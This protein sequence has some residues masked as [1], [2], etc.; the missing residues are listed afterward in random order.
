MLVGVSVGITDGVN[1][2][3]GVA[4]AVCDGVRL[5]RGVLVARAIA[6]AGR[7]GDLVNV[8]VSIVSGASVAGCGVAVSCGVTVLTLAKVFVGVDGSVVAVAAASCSVAM[9][10]AWVGSV[11]GSTVGGSVGDA[12]GGTNTVGAGVV[13]PVVAVALGNAGCVGLI[14]GTGEPSRAI[15][16]AVEMFTVGRMT[17]AVG[18][19]SPAKNGNRRTIRS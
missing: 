13:G 19:K 4:L 16:S 12:V 3:V 17:G 2:L 15:E 9:V 14:V 7:V 6:V 1:V 5:G 8:V 11:V 10:D 18:D